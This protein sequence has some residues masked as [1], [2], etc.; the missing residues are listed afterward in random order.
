MTDGTHQRLS[1]RETDADTPNVTMIGSLPPWKAITPYCREVFEGLRAEGESVQFINWRNLYPKRFYPGGD[2]RDDSEFPEES[3]V[4]NVLTWW[5]PLSWLYAGYRIEGDIVHAQWWSFPLI[6][7]YLTVLL[8][9]KLRGKTVV[10]TVHD[11]TPHERSLPN[12][13][14]N[15]LIYPV[16]DQFV[17]H[18]EENKRTLCSKYGVQRSQVTVISHPVIQSVPKK[19]VTMYT[20]KAELGIEQHRDVILS[21]GGIRDYKGIDTFLLDLADIVEENDDALLVIA[22][23][24]W[25]DWDKYERVIHEQGLDDHVRADIGYI[26]DEQVEYYF[27]A[28]DVVVFPYKNFEAQSGVASLCNYFGAYSIGFDRGG[29]KQQLVETVGGHEQ[30]VDR[31]LEL[32]DSES[33]EVPSAVDNDECIYDHVALYRRLLNGESDVLRARSA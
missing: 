4:L 11:V 31:I 14:L 8:I 29:L 27:A 2:P 24:L 20:A 32:L 19:D 18:S 21:F 13:V 12:I 33:R 23:A 28:A 1:E 6:P 25:D 30:L 16:A 26:P 15:Q 10:L 17:V 9:A 7:V 5:N 22:G 3:S